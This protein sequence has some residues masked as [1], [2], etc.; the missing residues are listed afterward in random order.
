VE[1]LLGTELDADSASL[2]AFWNNEDLT[3]WGANPLEVYRLAPINIH[4]TCSFG[5]RSGDKLG[6]EGDASV[7]WGW[8][9]REPSYASDITSVK[10]GKYDLSDFTLVS[11][12]HF[13]Y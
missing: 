10:F 3:G 5:L 7:M 6:R 13:G 4:P 1:D 8:W 12:V 11:I 9:L 2:A